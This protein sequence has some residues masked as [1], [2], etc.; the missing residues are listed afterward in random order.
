MIG[1]I[2]F[3]LL[4]GVA[5][6]F[7]ARR[8]GHIRSNIKLGR[9]LDRTDNRA[10]RWRT[11]ARV[12]L[13]QGKMVTRPVAGIMHIIIYVGFLIVNIE[14]LEIVLDG[15]SGHHRLFA[16]SLSSVYPFLINTF[17]IIAFL[18]V[19]SCVVFLARRWV[20][21]IKRFHN[22]EMKGWPTRDATI[23]LIWEMVLMFCLFSM[24]ATD[25]ILAARG[26]DHYTVA[27][28]FAISQ[29]L[30]PL[31]EGIADNGTLVMLER[32]FWWTHI[33]GIL[34]FLVYVTYSKHFHIILAFPNTWYS[35]LAQKGRMTNMEAVT[36]EVKLMMDPTADPYAAPP[37]D[38]APP[39]RFGAK[40]VQDLT[41][42]N[43][44][45][46]YTCTECGRCTSSCPAN[47]TGKKLSP[48][49]IMM[50]TR[51]R[52]E[53]VGVNIRANGEFQDDGKALLG[54]H[55]TEEELWACTSC[56]AC[57]EACPVNI[58]P[59]S[60]I[61]DMRRYL[62]ME[63]SKS[64]ESITAMFNNVENNG[65]PWAFSAMDRDKWR[66]ELNQA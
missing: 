50:D 44:M 12:A 51:D 21:N 55:I 26:V 14:L 62:I 66:E 16:G 49:K 2:A 20:M 40:D 34:G 37:A 3:A 24:N 39:Q 43:L 56:N 35:N 36:N 11:M 13:G 19:I 63:E 60:I 52:L 8:L 4:L 32:A 23:I 18:V 58:D 54:D 22:P 27:G 33:T 47:Q 46:A 25:S 31:Y 59:L 15:L 41:W 29:Y 64:P 9:D 57:V 17:E 53:V 10:A 42:K 45:D 48:R 5:V 30:V 28:P 6:F 65:A 61:L 38:A 1:Q 7:F